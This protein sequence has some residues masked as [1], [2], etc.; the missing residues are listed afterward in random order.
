MQAQFILTIGIDYKKPYGGVA[1]VESTYSLFYEPFQHVA[2]VTYGGK[3]EKFLVL[4]RAYPLFLLYMFDSSIRIVHV[5]GASDASFWRKTLFIL[6][7]KLFKKKVVYHMHGG[8]FMEFSKKYP[9]FV[10]FVVHQCD[11]IIALSEVWR[12]FFINKLYVNNVVVIPNPVELPRE[13]HSCRKD[14][15]I[16]FL[17]LGTI[18]HNKGIFDLLAILKNYKD[19]LEGKAKFVIGGIGEDEKLLKFIMEND[20]TDLVEYRGW[21]GGEEKVKLFNESHVFILPSYIEGVPICI[22]E[23]ETYHLPIITT[24]VGGIP[25]IVQHGLNGYLLEPGCLDSIAKAI[26]EMINDDSKRKKMGEASFPFAEPHL[27]NSVEKELMKLYS[28]IL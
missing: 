21:I 7:A 19:E 22:L 26:L 6:T 3:F 12:D 8:G 20:I 17:F 25:S 18:N 14:N 28:S 10:R 2:T 4:L 15:I 9:K 13:D 5:H 11:A 23:A 1:A 24:N 16:K 27:A